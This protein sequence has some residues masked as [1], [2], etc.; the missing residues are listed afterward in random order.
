MDKIT[1]KLDINPSYEWGEG[2]N[3]MGVSH[4][5]LEVFALTVEGFSDKETAQILHINHQSVKNHVYAMYKKMGVKNSTQAL[6]L[7]LQKKKN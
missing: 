5:E 6:L 4:R 7:L 1:Y 2:A 3:D